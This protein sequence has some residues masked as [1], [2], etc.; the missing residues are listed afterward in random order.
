MSEIKFL[1]NQGDNYYKILQKS[2]GSIEFKGKN[3][4]NINYEDD[5]LTF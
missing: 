4:Q 1:A 3:Y 5:E 2:D